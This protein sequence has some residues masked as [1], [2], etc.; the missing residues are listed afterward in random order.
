MWCGDE[1]A[2]DGKHYRLS[3]PINAPQAVRRPPILIGGAGEQKTL[4]LVA[5]Y[6]DACNL[7]DIPDG[8]VTL[9]HKLAVLAKHCEEVGRPYEEIEKTV[10]TRY[11]PGESAAS[12]AGR[13]AKLAELGAEHLVVITDGPWTEESITTVADAAR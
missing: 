13:C 12:F 10:S 7:F 3:R 8:G 2:F 5:K 9:T 6:A 11:R 4:R 1:D